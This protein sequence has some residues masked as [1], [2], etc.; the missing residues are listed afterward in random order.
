MT[1]TQTRV[2]AGAVDPFGRPAGGRF[3]SRECPRVYAL[4]DTLTPPTPPP[5][6]PPESGAWPDPDNPART[7]VAAPKCPH[8]YFARYAR[9]TN[10]R[11]GRPNCPPCH[12]TATS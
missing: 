4:L 2:P 1:S 8:G 5:E 12:R 7:I 9:G 11:T 10:P 3:A 6:R